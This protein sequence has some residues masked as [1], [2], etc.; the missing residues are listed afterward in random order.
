MPTW[1]APPSACSTTCS[2]AFA[3]ESLSMRSETS[4]EWRSGETATTRA[5]CTFPVARRAVSPCLTNARNWGSSTVYRCELMMITS[6]LAAAASRGKALAIASAALVDSG[7]PMTFP[8]ELSPCSEVATSASATSTAIPQ[9]TNVQRG[10]AAQARANRS[11]NPM[12]AVLL[13]GD[14][15]RQISRLVDVEAAQPRD[16]IGEQLK[17]DHGERCLEE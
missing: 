7:L 14:R 10:L 1:N 5:P 9:P 11:V 12:A 2:T 16:A 15:L 17:R 13:D 8:C 4:T 3:P 6:P